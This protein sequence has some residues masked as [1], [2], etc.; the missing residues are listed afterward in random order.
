M[1]SHT[2]N[3]E[4][5]VEQIKDEVRAAARAEDEAGGAAA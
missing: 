3:T 4:A 5:T 2:I 1:T